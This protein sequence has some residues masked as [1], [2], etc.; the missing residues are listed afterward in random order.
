MTLRDLRI[1]KNI[2]QD[3]LSAITGVSQQYI[4]KVENGRTRM[5]RAMGAK[6]MQKFDLT[7]EQVWAMMEQVPQQE[8]RGRR[9]PY[10]SSSIKR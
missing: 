1:E 8:R 6:L 10:A 5:S 9:G 7:L 3:E 2:T 4:S